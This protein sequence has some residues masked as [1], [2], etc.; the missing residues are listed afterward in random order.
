MI[1]AIITGI[2]KALG[3]CIVTALGWVWTI[4]RAV[5]S[6][7][8][9]WA[10]K[11]LMRLWTAIRSLPDRIK[12]PLND[13]QTRWN[14]KRRP[15][16][17]TEG[18][19]LLQLSCQFAIIITLLML[20]NKS[21]HKKGIATVRESEAPHYDARGFQST[22]I[23]SLKIVWATV[24]AWIISLYSALWSAMLDSLKAVH[25]DLELNKSAQKPIPGIKALGKVWQSIYQRLPLPSSWRRQSPPPSPQTASVV[26]STAKRTMLLDYGEWPIY[27][28]YKAMRTG[29]IL[30]GVCLWL[31]AALWT[32]GGLSAAIFDVA[33]VPFQTGV[34]LYSDTF[35]DE[36]LGFAEGDVDRRQEPPLP[37]FD[38]VS[39]TLI[40]GGQNLSWTTGT[41]SFLPY[42]PLQI[43]SPGN[44]TFDTEAYWASIDCDYYTGDK[45]RTEGFL[46][47]AL[48]DPELNSA[49]IRLHYS[50]A[51][52][53]IQKWFNVFNTTSYYGR[54]FSTTECGLASGRARLGFF[55]GSYRDSRIPAADDFLLTEMV[56]L[57][58]KPDFHRSNVTVTVS[59]S[60]SETPGRKPVAQILHFEEKAGSRE[61]FWPWFFKGLL[62]DLPTYSSGRPVKDVDSFGRL[63]IDHASDRPRLDYIPMDISLLRSFEAVFRGV[64]SNYVSLM[65]YSD[66]SRREVQG[67]LAHDQVRLFVVYQATYAVVGIVG[68]A[69]LTT[70][71][72]AVHLF[73]NRQI[74]R[75]HQGLMLGNAFLLRNTTASG[76]ATGV[77]RYL[78]AVAKKATATPG[79]NLV[80]VAEQDDDLKNW[81]AWAEKGF[82][83]M[84]N[85][86][87]VSS[88]SSPT[89]APNP[90]S[91]SGTLLAQVGQSSTHGNAGSIQMQPLSSS[92]QQ[93]PNP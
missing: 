35:F 78:E 82:M 73:W 32:A 1:G 81:E 2:P 61:P 36:L 6:A 50:H 8:G 53:K 22:P 12:Q 56:I 65:A 49:Q 41:H 67:T 31:R 43:S 51:G 87:S 39:A 83:H 5:F 4:T 38:M 63:V 34:R 7:L 86:L 72:L 70:L 21:N 75:N 17:L 33:E 59:I 46:E 37:A 23:F 89:G 24:P 79:V 93:V 16:L 74:I 90:P 71:F 85:P 40:R 52:C 25:T 26:H 13:I 3:S 15:L 76:E 18:G 80:K 60:N 62:D 19:M 14:S 48:W 55:S 9:K 57:T 42:L 69:M 88:G 66:A 27:N 10:L 54:S 77:S 30:L 20:L 47:Q 84:K 28:G 58:C 45:L 68:A 44:Y 91:G 64:Y 92:G 29:H 11:I